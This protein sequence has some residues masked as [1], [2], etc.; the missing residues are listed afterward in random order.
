MLLLS[1][2]CIP[3]TLTTDDRWQGGQPAD[4]RWEG[5]ADSK[6]R[7]RSSRSRSSD[8]HRR[9]ERSRSPDRHH[10]DRDHRD[11]RHGSRRGDDQERRV[12]RDSER[13]AQ[14]SASRTP[15]ADDGASSTKVKPTSGIFSYLN[16]PLQ[17]VGGAA[18]GS[19][20]AAVGDGASSSLRVNTGALRRVLQDDKR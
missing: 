2:P 7:R 9:W 4:D 12:S 17:S 14:S 11:H 5:G 3:R 16:L 13:G 1:P 19:A 10:R 18:A 6:R 20:A 8:R 15:S